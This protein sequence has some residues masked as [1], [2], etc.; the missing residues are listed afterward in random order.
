MVIVFHSSKLILADPEKIDVFLSEGVLPHIIMC[1]QSKYESVIESSLHTTLQ[2]ARNSSK[3][4]YFFG[5][6]FRK[7]CRRILQS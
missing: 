2:M 3:R 5:N 6:H 4:K 1:M 7:V